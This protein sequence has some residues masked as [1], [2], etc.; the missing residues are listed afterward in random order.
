MDVPGNI[1]K[2]FNTFAVTEVIILETVVM[3]SRKD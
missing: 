3:L 2:T 1:F